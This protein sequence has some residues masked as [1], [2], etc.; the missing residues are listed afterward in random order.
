MTFTKH[1]SIMPHIVYGCMPTFA[2]EIYKHD[3]DVVTE[4]IVR[5]D[6]AF[7]EYCIQPLSTSFRCNLVFCLLLD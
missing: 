3:S 6:T 1:G 7:G 4:D 2:F 5:L